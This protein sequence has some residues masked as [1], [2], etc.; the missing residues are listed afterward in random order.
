MKEFLYFC[1]IPLNM[2]N[3][4]DVRLTLDQA[5]GILY[6]ARPDI[7]AETS[8]LVE[9]G[10]VSSCALREHIM[11]HYVDSSRRNEFLR[12]LAEAV[13]RNGG[14]LKEA[15]QYLPPGSIVKMMDIP[16]GLNLLELDSR[17]SHSRTIPVNHEP[18]VQILI[19]YLKNGPLYTRV[20]SE[21]LPSDFPS[22]LR[23][24]SNLERLLRDNMVGRRAGLFTMQSDGRG[25]M[26]E[27]LL[28]ADQNVPRS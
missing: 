21:K 24:L 13:V 20:L 25:Y 1:F 11:E 5:V 12:K 3:Y 8:G 14:A 26:D 6:L 4:A 17:L 27:K 16:P 19:T 9:D 23:D 28:T 7:W 22:R 18:F 15:S 2:S 10:H